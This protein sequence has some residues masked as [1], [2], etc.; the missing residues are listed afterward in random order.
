MILIITAYAGKPDL[1]AMTETMLRQLKQSTDEC[2]FDEF[3]TLVVANGPDKLID[4]AIINGW[5]HQLILKDNIG[6]GK[7]INA[8][9][10]GWMRDDVTDVLVINNDMEFPHKDWLKNLLAAR[11]G[12]YVISPCTD[13]T[14]ASWAVASGPRDKPA[15][16]HSYVS[17]YC[18]LV[19]SRCIKA[20]KPRFGFELFDPEFFAYGEDDYTGAI[21]R[22]IYGKT[23]FKIVPRSWIKHLKGKTGLQMG[24]RG[25]MKKNLD[26]LKQKLRANKLK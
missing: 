12:S 1:T 13:R 6:F 4:P 19:P 22:K 11:E 10:K 17:A 9:I 23:P 7:A 5:G 26:L 2:E 3:R 15:F 25:G 14:A 16:R 8:G 21:L 18:W 20:I 24:L